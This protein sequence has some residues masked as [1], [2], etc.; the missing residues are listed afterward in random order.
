VTSASL[1]CPAPGCMRRSLN[2]SCR[3]AM[4]DHRKIHASLER[5]LVAPDP[6]RWCHRLSQSQTP[7][8]AKAQLPLTPSRLELCSRMTCSSD[9]LVSRT[10]PANQCAKFYAFGS[11]LSCLVLPSASTVWLHKR[12]PRM[13]ASRIQVELCGCFELADPR[14]A[15]FDPNLPTASGRI[16]DL[17]AEI[18]QGSGLTSGRIRSSSVSAISLLANIPLIGSSSSS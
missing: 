16:A 14:R 12:Y 2:W 7:R 15:L 13:V 11:R 3:A 10:Q 1:S 18:R 8:S 9:T 5:L 6:I 4:R 17:Y